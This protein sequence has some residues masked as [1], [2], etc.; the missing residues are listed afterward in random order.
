M[1][2][3]TRSELEALFAEGEPMT[4]YERADAVV[5]L[6]ADDS[7]ASIIASLPHP[8]KEEF[9]EFGRRAYAPDGERLLIKGA[10]LPEVCLA[11][12]R[13]WLRTYD[14]FARWSATLDSIARA[15]TEPSSP[16]SGFV[17]QAPPDLRLVETMAKAGTLP[18]QPA[19]ACT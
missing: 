18:R 10:P 12:F 14:T 3:E 8:F 19:A 16:P 15:L 17:P 1:K 6:F 5:R 9:I 4:F 13:A 7:V 11:A 2:P